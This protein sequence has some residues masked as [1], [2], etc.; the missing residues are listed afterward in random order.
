MKGV[1]DKDNIFGQ[2]HLY[3]FTVSI[4]SLITNFSYE[5]YISL[6]QWQELCGFMKK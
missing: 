1:F 3:S 6:D 5:K 4:K 2:I